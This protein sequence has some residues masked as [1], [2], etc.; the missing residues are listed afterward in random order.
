VNGTCRVNGTDRSLP[1]P[2]TVVGLLDALELRLGTVVIELNGLALTRPEAA[3]APLAEGD[4]VE[5]VR[6]VAGG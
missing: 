1:T 3:V 2:S 4:V 5:I 6:A